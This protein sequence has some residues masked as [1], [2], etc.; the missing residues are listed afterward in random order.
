[1]EAYARRINEAKQGVGGEKE[2][3]EVDQGRRLRAYRGKRQ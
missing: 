3:I 1:M 2:E